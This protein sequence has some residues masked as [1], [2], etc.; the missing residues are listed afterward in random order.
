MA[1]EGVEGLMITI[2]RYLIVRP[3]IITAA[4][5]ITMTDEDRGND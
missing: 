1:I 2:N 3:T 4:T 5:I